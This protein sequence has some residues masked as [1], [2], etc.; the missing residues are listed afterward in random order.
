MLNAIIAKDI[1]D[2]KKQQKTSEL[3]LNFIDI[4]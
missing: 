1:S 2:Y 4:L 3:P